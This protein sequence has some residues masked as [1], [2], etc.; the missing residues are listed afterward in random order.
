MLGELG[1]LDQSAQDVFGPYE[2][3]L[4]NGRRLSSVSA[5]LRAPDGEAAALPCVNL[6]RTPLEQ[7]AAVLSSFCAP[8]TP[9]PKPL[10]EQ[11]WNERVQYIVGAYV[12]ECGRPVERLTRTD[13]LT[14][15][16]RLQEAKV[17]TVR[18][19]GPAVAAAL[20]VSRSTLYGLLA[21]LRTPESRTP[22]HDP[23]A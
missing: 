17:F 9:R 4:A 12:R 8:T 2:K 3:T 11:D 20:R 14:L 23:S 5:V 6:D 22:R 16:A 7:A 10:F 15:L 13:R 19:A 18:R 1:R 21:E